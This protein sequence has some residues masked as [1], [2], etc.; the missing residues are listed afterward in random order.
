MTIDMTFK[1]TK[2]SEI[3]VALD[4][5]YKTLWSTL[6]FDYLYDEGNSQS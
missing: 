1:G 4:Y 6:K 2:S 3:E 5:S